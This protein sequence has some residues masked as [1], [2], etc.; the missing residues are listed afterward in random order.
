MM[1]LK[2]AVAL[3]VSALLTDIVT[4][5]VLGGHAHH[6]AHLNKTTIPEFGPLDARQNSR[7][8]L[9]IMPLGASIVAGQGSSA[10]NG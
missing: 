4:A 1:F 3:L 2:S 6:H 10:G 8:A 7:P 9:R 5:G